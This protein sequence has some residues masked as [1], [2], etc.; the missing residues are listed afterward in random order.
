MK[1]S[2]HRPTSEKEAMRSD[3]IY[4]C[5]C[6]EYVDFWKYD[7]IADT[8]HKGHKWRY[9]TQRELKTCAKDCTQNHCFE[10]VIL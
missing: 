1:R 10:E 3:Y 2:K 5:D 6:K 4:C 7:S 9:V 8:G